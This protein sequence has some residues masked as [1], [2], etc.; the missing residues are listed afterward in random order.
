MNEPTKELTG[1]LTQQ[2][3]SGSSARASFAGKSQAFA[4]C[5]DR[6][7]N[8]VVAYV[9]SGVSDN[10][11]FRAFRVENTT[12]VEAWTT[13]DKPTTATITADSLTL[14]TYPGVVIASTSSLIDGANIGN[15]ISD[16][17][18]SQ[19][20][21]A[22]D[23]DIV[24]QM[25]EGAGTEIAEA[26]SLATIAQAQAALM[27]N[28]FS[29]D[30]AVVSPTLYG[31]LA[32]TSGGMLL[33]G[34]DPRGAQMTVLGSTLVVSSA[35]TGAACVVADKSAVVAIE[36]SE[37]PVALVAQQPSKNTTE[38]C[39]EIVAAGYVAKPDGVVSVAAA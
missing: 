8:A 33:G 10:S 32:G 18:Y 12:P 9:D 39:V 30:I 4:W 17:L 14:D 35:L 22:L 34:N 28:G 19:A 25:V 11:A 27:G 38:I 15:A 21:R 20:L 7:T 24:G 13:G 26:A 2:L 3:S 6:I 36:H 5:A 1:V 31:T 23:A 37:S 29:A 16:A